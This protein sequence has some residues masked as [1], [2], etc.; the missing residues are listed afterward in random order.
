[1]P[2]FSQRSKDRLATCH[3]DLQR[4]MNKVVE[5]YDISIICGHRGEEEHRLHAR[6]CSFIRYV[7]EYAF[8]SR[9]TREAFSL[10]YPIEIDGIE[11]HTLHLRRVTVGDL[12]VIENEKSERKK[13]IKLL[14]RLSGVPENEIRH[15]DVTD[16]DKATDKVLVFLGVD[17]QASERS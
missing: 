10:E 17:S 13:V 6:C 2:A 3:P 9:K 14:A 11:T 1:M 5:R 8:M 4:V 7:Q 15:L 16:F 12:E